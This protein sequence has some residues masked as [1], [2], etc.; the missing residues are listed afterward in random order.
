V[1]SITWHWRCPSCRSYDSLQSV[2]NRGD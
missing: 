1:A 2:H